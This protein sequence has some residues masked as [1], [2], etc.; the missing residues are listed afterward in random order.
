VPEG[1]WLI[2]NT[3]SALA[4]ARVKGG[5]QSAR[6]LLQQTYQ[7][8]VEALGPDHEITKRAAERLR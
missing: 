8:L 1:H 6:P 4:F 5:G 7:S 2:T 3:E